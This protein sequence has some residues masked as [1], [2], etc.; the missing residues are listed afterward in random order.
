MRE[1]I[2]FSNN[3]NKI[4][5]ISALFKYSNI[6]IL[7]LNNFKNKILSPEET[8]NTFD[9][10]AK[11]KSL[12]GYNFFKK[13]CFA[14]DSGICI[15]ALGG[16][17][18]INS[19][20]FLESNK[21]STDK[22]I[23]IILLTKK[24]NNFLAFFQTSICLSLSSDHVIYFKGKIKGKISKEI[25]GSNGFG[26]DPIFIP[27]GEDLTFAEMTNQKKNSLSHRAIAIKKLKRY[28]DSSI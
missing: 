5:E 19:K 22:L 8:G 12:F 1:I 9:N 15:E 14:D 16:G 13:Y 10:N 25:K 17:P 3:K 7:S 11:I 23:E 2:F 6:K 26:Y 27:D 4:K 28:L 24:K 21:N 18:G 20:K